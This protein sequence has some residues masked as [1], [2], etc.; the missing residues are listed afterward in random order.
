MPDSVDSL[1]EIIASLRDVD[2]LITREKD[3]H[4]L[5]S[6]ACRILSRM[7][8]NVYSWILLM[9]GSGR[10]TDSAETGIGK[11]FS[12]ILRMAEEGALPHCVNQ[13]MVSTE[14]II[15][16]TEEPYCSSC[17]LKEEGYL[18]LESCIMRLA[19]EEELLGIMTIGFPAESDIDS[20][21]LNLFTEIAED[22]AYALHGIRAECDR[23]R[24]ERSLRESET[25]LN[26][27]LDH[28]PGPA[29]IR[30][31]ESRYLHVNTFFSQHFG[32]PEKWLGKAPDDLFTG[33]F[34]SRM[35]R[36]DGLALEKG[37]HVYEKELGE[38]DGRSV[39]EVHCFRIDTDE[40]DPLIGGI[41]FDRTE[42]YRWKEAL[43]ESEERYRAVFQN[44]GSATVLVDE[45]KTI[46][47]ANRGFER[48]SGYSTGELCGRMKW[49][50]FVHPD[51]LQMM[52]SYHDD[53]RII[54]RGVPNQYEFRF[55]DREG[56][57]KHVNLQVDLIPGTKE[58]VC[59]LLDITELK[60]TQRQLH[61]SVM[62]MESLLRTMPD[63]MFVLT[64]DGEYTDFWVGDNEMLAIPADRIVGSNIKQLG[65]SRSKYREI[66]SKL[67]LTLETGGVQSVEYDLN[68][69]E[70]RGY[71][72]ARLAPYGDRSVIA[73]IRDI[74]ARRNAEKER[75]E[76][77]ARI[78]HTQKLESLGVLAGGIAHDFNNILMTILG[79]ADL[80][81]MN[82]KRGDPAAAFLGE[83]TRA[84]STASDLARQM[85]A[86]SGRSDFQIQ[87]LNLNE[88]ITEL[89]NMMEVSISKKVV[90][91]Y[92]LAE[93]LPPVMADATQIRQ[94]IMNLIT[95]ASEAIGEKSGYISITT[96]AVYCDRDYLDS[97]ELSD[98]MEEKMYV[99]IEVADT[100]CGM[101]D[102]VKSQLFEPFF[103][104]KYTGR[105][106]GLS[107]V[108]GIVR[109]HKGAI[110]VYSEP[111]E[112]STFKILL[113]VS[114][115]D[116]EDESGA[117][118]D[119]EGSGWTGSGTVLF[120]DDE[121][122]VLAIGRK[123]LQQIGFNV[124]SAEDGKRAV[125]LF[126][127]YSGGIDLVILD[128]TMPH[129]S[130]DEVYREIKW[131]RSDVPVIL[132]SGFSRREVIHRFA[133][134]HLDGFLQKPYRTEDLI[135]VIRS[136]IEGS[137][138]AENDGG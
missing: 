80:A 9:D 112:G 12:N 113:P 134:R 6:E 39:Y 26:A 116:P 126:E 46:I 99:Y 100:G 10:I 57:L 62:H 77:E 106:L 56:C 88:L 111:N 59:S 1:R 65:L 138:D 34:A 32:P 55:V 35:F 79:N 51:D 44:T 5:I 52:I 76:L 97:T 105:G 129:L 8:G 117:S 133:G 124:I 21:H 24:T 64:E 75:L 91:R 30:D 18:H 85:L 115:S 121:D 23:K 136:V 38:G 11:D 81:M 17:R 68:L 69:G 45:T 27:F 119:V 73:V 84:A 89:T 95:N 14:P 67:Q 83:I 48:L 132:S 3:S 110:K 72:E 128:L 104:T 49:T 82:L 78:Q 98:Q 16:R 135:S 53:R 101:D 31:A 130:G 92:R 109:G 20:A 103:T 25:L 41:A 90:I 63:L 37:Y 74:T 70:D 2:R 118:A 107:S 58:S 22:I 13:A 94:I 28:F 29:F 50:V 102:E 108:L 137:G 60:E 122:T 86:Y 93:H 33:D 127:K 7:A 120:A 36:E 47:M 61:Q 66:M 40:N 87:P 131:V 19:H 96:G 71:Y 125:E 114:E 43:K 54:D 123:M 15:N 4:R 42:W